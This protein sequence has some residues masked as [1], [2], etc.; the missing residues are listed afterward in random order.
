MTCPKCDKIIKELET[1]ETIIPIEVLLEHISE[2]HQKIADLEKDCMDTG[3]ENEG[4]KIKIEKLEDEIQK[5][6]Q[7]SEVDRR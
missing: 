3:I 5:L 6:K 2:L 1:G 4:H 7:K